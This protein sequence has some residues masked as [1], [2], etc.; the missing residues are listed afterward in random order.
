MPGGVASRTVCCPPM[1][2]RSPTGLRRNAH[3]VLAG[4]AVSFVGDYIAIV[5]FPLF[6]LQLTGSALDLGF[7][8]AFETLPTVLFGFAVGVVLDRVVLRRALIIA[9]LGRAT[10]FAVLAVAIASGAA[11]VWMVFAVAFLVGTLAVGFDSGLQAWLP[12]LVPGDRLVWMN[13][14]LAMARAAAWS[15]GPPLAGFL[16]GS[17]RGFGVA[18]GIDAATFVV[19]AGFI[20]LL[21]EVRP[22]EV[23]AHDRPWRSFAAGIRYL[24]REQRLRI[25]TIG[26]MAANTL[27]VPL[28]A[29]LA[30]FAAESLDITSGSLFGWFI[31][32]HS[33]LGMLG[34][35][36]APRLARRIGLGRTFVVGLGMLGGGFFVLAVASEAIGSLSQVASTITAAV[37]AGIAVAGVSLTN[38]AFY[39]LRQQIPPEQ[40]LGRVIA[41]SRTLAWAGLPVGAALGGWIGDTLGTGAVYLGGTVL[42]LGLA[43]SLVPTALYRHS[44]EAESTAS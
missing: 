19:S 10:A 37:P 9:D 29:L 36:V 11:Q 40:L 18:F 35:A 17:D 30:L 22:R 27:F 8:A 16:A 28:E 2:S 12:A 7:T 15:V 13:S 4:Q 25:A 3:L 24:A 5:A 31:A 32:A 1:A 6:I 20:V 34:L 23:V 38:M 33:L 21:V 44:P 41:A 14:R 26:A 43:V 42:L 39:T